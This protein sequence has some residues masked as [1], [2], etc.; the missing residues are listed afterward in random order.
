VSRQ[1]VLLS[2][3]ALASLAAHLGA[4]AAGAR[5]LVYAFKPL[6]TLL[7]IAVAW[8]LGRAEQAP[9]AR[10]YT[11]P[12]LAGLAC[13][14]VGDVALMLPG[15]Y[16]VPGLFAF[17]AA[18]LCYISAF[19]ARAGGLRP[20]PSALPFAFA[21]IVLVARLAPHAGTLLGPVALYGAVLLAMA[22]CAAETWRLRRDGPTGAA[23]VGALLFVVSDTLLAFGRFVPAGPRSGTAVMITYVAAQLLIAWSVKPV[24][25][26]PR[27]ARM[28]G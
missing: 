25:R 3:A 6:T 27:A 21:Y 17:L 7:V 12:V 20:S 15:D 9:A 22:W 5:V 18:H 16:F 8:T 2:L 10:R 4:E 1:P 26:A 19:A 13:S 11:R 28:Q 14:L 24:S 23:A